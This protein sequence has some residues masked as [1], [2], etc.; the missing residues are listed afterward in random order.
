MTK[1]KRTREEGQKLV[2]EFTASGLSQ[3]KFV[4]KKGMKLA[5]LQYWLR[6]LRNDERE[7]ELRFVEVVAK[8]KGAV[9]M[10]LPGGAVVHFDVLPSTEYLANLAL[11]LSKRAGC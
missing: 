7:A 10:E 8:E 6:K 9:R 4:E 3:A 2:A 1:A 11:E 5:S